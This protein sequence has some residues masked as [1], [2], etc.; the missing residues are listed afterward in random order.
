MQQIPFILTTLA[1]LGVLIFLVR[2]RWQTLRHS[3]RRWL[4]GVFLAAIALF[5]SGYVT[6]WVTISDRLNSAVYWAAVAGY[7]L[8]LSIHSL[9]RPR[10]ITS[11]TAIVLAAPILASSLF[12][13]LG[14]IFHPNPRR[15]VALGN[16]LYASWQPFVETGASSSGVDVE[17]FYRP[18]ILPF[19]QHSR[20]GG[21]FYNRRCN[22]GATEVALQPNHNF[23]FVR[24][25][26]WPNSTD[27]SPGELLRL[28]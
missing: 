19:L 24:C 18:P 15:V 26:P 13:P 20:L 23:A 6:H 27:S 21:R 28:H 14:S 9:T 7:L 5:V 22:A 2:S 11:I 12:L 25:P 4:L 1:A 3:T 17:I 10:W 16:D 8:L